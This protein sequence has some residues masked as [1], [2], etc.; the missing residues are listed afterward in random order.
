MMI[1]RAFIFIVTLYVISIALNSCGCRRPTYYYLWKDFSIEIIDNT[2]FG[3]NP[4]HL[5][6]NEP[7]A[8]T[9]LGF[10]VH[11]VLDRPIQRQAKFNIVSEVQAGVCFPERLHSITSIEIKA[12]SEDK[13]EIDATS[14]FRGRRDWSREEN[15]IDK[16][17]R[18][19]NRWPQTDMFDLVLRDNSIDLTG[20]QTFEIT[21]TFDDGI[22]LTQKTEELTLI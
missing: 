14:L 21:I 20:K 11:S 19:V 17:I 1:K 9:K 5:N 18:I 2:S 22:V 15:S 6:P 4:N 12:R 10:R 7:I 13:I 16:L 8:I 3:Q